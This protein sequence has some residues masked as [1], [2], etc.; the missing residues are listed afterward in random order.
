MYMAGLVGSGTPINTVN[1]IP[2]QSQLYY[3]TSSQRTKKNIQSPIDFNSENLYSLVAKQYMYINDCVC[4]DKLN[5]GFIAE[6]VDAVDSNL[7]VR[8]KLGVLLKEEDNVDNEDL[9]QLVPTNINWYAINTYTVMEVQK[10]HSQVQVLKASN[11]SLTAENTTLKA[12]VQ[13]I[14]DRLTAA[15]IA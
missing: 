7:S 8:D 6:E 9:E 12:Q 11:Q 4:P 2:S 10:L 5:I 13:S 3:I 15:N 1:Y 14:L